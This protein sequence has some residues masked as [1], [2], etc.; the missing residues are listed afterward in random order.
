MISFICT[1]N[2]R[3][4]PGAGR[5]ESLRRLHSRNFL[6]VF[7]VEVKEAHNKHTGFFLEKHPRNMTGFWW[8]FWCFLNNRQNQTFW[9][10]MSQVLCSFQLWN[11][12][13]ELTLAAVKKTW[14]FFPL[15]YFSL[16]TNL[17]KTSTSFFARFFEYRDISPLHLN[18]ELFVSPSFSA[19]KVSAVAAG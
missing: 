6:L 1:A 4:A 9:F 15:L 17:R 10:L 11:I 19:P 8:G 2:G 16:N 12:R 13:N 3:L 5:I 14:T 7:G 18:T